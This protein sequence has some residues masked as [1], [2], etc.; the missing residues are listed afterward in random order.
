MGLCS[1]FFKILLLNQLRQN[2]FCSFFNTG[3][4]KT[5]SKIATKQNA[6]TILHN[7]IK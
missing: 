1:F 2:H 3:Y 4:Y 7:M 6:A 5:R